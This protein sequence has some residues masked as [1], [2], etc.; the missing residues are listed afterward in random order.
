M[1]S[2]FFVSWFL[3]RLS[4]AGA[5]AAGAGPVHLRHLTVVLAFVGLFVRPGAASGA[6]ISAAGA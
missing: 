6:Y 4:G 5:E 1:R 3:I 2:P